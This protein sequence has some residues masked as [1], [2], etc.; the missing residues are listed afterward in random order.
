VVNSQ[1]VYIGDTVGN[2]RV[3]AITRESVTLT[4]NGQDKVLTLK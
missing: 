2:G 3:K 1:T 4:I